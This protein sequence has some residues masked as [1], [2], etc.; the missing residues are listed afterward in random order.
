[1]KHY[2]ESYR[3]QIGEALAGTLITRQPAQTLDLSE[4]FD[5]AI[6]WF[7]QTHS[8]WGTIYFCGNGASAAMA[9]H[10]ALDWAKCAQVKSL[11]FNDL[12]SL[13]AFGNDTGFDNVFSL[14][15]QLFANA[16]DILVTISSS[17]NS[18]NVLQALKTAAKLG[19]RTITLSGFQ[20]DNKSRAMGEL[21]FYVP[22]KTYGI[23][24]SVHQVILHAW[25]D[26]YVELYPPASA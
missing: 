22:A 10:M 23:A 19:M 2:F 25:L 3:E 12:V 6:D 20:P 11:C 14:P 9:S 5:L 4:G 17:G 18:P 13:T 7:R 8:D 26:R 1:M 24:E 16:K 21:N 15:L